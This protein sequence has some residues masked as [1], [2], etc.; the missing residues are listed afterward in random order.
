[1]ISGQ[2]L[3]AVWQNECAWCV[4][5]VGEASLVFIIEDWNLSLGFFYY[6]KKESQ[7]Q[8]SD[9]WIFSNIFFPNFG[10]FS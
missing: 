9:E 1:M 6:Q 10:C 4:F 3:N 2:I 5:V 8:A 7:L